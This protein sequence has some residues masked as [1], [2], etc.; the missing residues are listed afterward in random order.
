[1]MIALTLL[2]FCKGRSNQPIEGK[3]H[4]T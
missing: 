4:K 3:S 2:R 1:V